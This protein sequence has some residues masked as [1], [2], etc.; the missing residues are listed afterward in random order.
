M[1]HPSPAQVFDPIEAVRVPAMRDSPAQHEEFREATSAAVR[2]VLIV[3][4]DVSLAS[5]L[6]SEFQARN[7]LIELVHDGEEA[8]AAFRDDRRYDLLILDLNLPKLD[9]ISLIGRI[10]PAH[11]RLPVLVLT[12]RGRVEDRVHA[13]QSGADDCLGKPFSLLELLARTQALL[14]RNSGVIPNC[15]RV[16]DLI[17]NRDER[18]VERNGRRIDLTPREFAIL[19]FMMRNAG[20]PVSRTTLLEEVWNNAGEPATNIVDVY[21]KYVRDKVDTAGYTREIPEISE[22]AQYLEGG[23]VTGGGVTLDGV[24]SVR[25]ELLNLQIQQQ[26]SEQNSA[27]TQSSSLQSIQPLF[28]SS[29]TDIAGMFSAFSNSL[30]QLSADPTNSAIRQSVISAGQNLASSFNSTAN[31]LSSAQTNADRQ[32]TATVAQINS[33]TLQLSKLNAE[34]AQATNN[35]NDGGTIQ[36]QRDQLVQQLSALTGISVTQSSDGEVITTGDGTPLVMGGLSNSLQTATGSNGMQ[37]VLDANGNDI[38]AS[39]SSGQLGGLIQL[40]DHTIPAFFDS[41]NQL[42]SQFATSFNAAQ[43]AGYTSNGSPGQPFFSIPA[44]PSYAASGISV[45]ISDASQIAASS[46]GSPGS[47]RNVANLSAVLTSPLPSGQTPVDAYSSLVF[48]V[49]NAASNAEAQ[50]SAIS[51]SILQL[52]NQQSSVSGVSIDEESANLIRFQTAYEAAARIVSTVQ[53][54]NTAT[55]NMVS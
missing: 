26:T 14:R 31:G 49:G 28:S 18:R 5:F 1:G 48:Q 45:A 13:L 38:T 22:L 35:G 11:P 50:S 55:I 16:C 41:L 39:I 23:A 44:N 21:M 47:G 20:R 25:D 17:L 51:Q 12:A 33:L 19:E 36:D 53:A 40:R 42:A 4:D 9:G 6:C 43:A 2:R 30:A 34:F 10:R 27:D 3:E 24:Q 37:E 52:T 7:Y 54:L 46:D 29:G 32:V 15:S 8:L